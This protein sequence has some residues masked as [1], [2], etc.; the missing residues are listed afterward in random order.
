VRQDHP[1]GENGETGSAVREEFCSIGTPCSNI[2]DDWK[3]PPKVEGMLQKNAVNL[4][5][6]VTTKTQ[7]IKKMLEDIKPN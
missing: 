7:D 6:N 2:T 1:Q 5:I 4:L 3:I